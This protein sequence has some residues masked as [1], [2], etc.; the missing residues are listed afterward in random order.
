MMRNLLQI[1]FQ[2]RNRSRGGLWFTLFFAAAFTGFSA[3]F[4]ASLDRD[5]IMMGETA[6]LTLKFE[7]G[8]PKS[9]PTPPNIPNLQIAAPGSSQNYS[10]VNGQTSTSI[11]ETFA[12]LAKPPA[13][14]T[15]PA[16]TAELDA[17][18]PTSQSLK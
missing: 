7:G 6:T 1:G 17:H 12:I 15:I 10:F 18:T 13:E 9:V 4:T 16:L 3:S 2:A 14:N 8:S 5:T 11:A